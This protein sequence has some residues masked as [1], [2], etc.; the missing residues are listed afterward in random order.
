MSNKT[1]CPMGHQLEGA[2][3]VKANMKKGQRCCR[4]CCNARS[5]IERHPERGNDLKVISDGYFKKYATIAPTI[6]K[7]QA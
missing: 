7:E 6:F 4:S 3:L 5:Y 1:H 2:N